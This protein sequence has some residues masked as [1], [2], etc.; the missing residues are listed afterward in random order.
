MNSKWKDIWSRKSL[1][2]VD[3]GKDEFS[4]FCELKKADGF[5]VNVHNEELYFRA[6]Y[7]EWMEM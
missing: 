1:E 2:G 5:D 3:L 7:D 4:V 6:F